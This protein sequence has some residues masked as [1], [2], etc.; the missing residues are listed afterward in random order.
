MIFR[1]LQ[2]GYT[3]LGYLG[4]SERGFFR[5]SEFFPEPVNP[6]NSCKTNRDS[7]IFLIHLLIFY[8]LRF[9]E[10]LQQ[11]FHSQADLFLPSSKSNASLFGL[12][13]PFD[14]AELIWSSP[15]ILIKKSTPE[16]LARD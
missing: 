3:R 5:V 4:S 16:S 2:N 10:L 7:A 14:I 1:R 13:P 15:V 9:L 11:G 6:H 8:L 12:A